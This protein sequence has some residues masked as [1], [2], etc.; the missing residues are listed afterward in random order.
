MV[1]TGPSLEVSYNDICPADTDP[2]EVKPYMAMENPQK[3]TIDKRKAFLLD[4]PSFT[5]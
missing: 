3:A 4:Y 1:A 2:L 5:L